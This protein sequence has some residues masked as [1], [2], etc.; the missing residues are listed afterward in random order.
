[1]KIG[2]TTLFSYR[3]HVEHMFY[4]AKQLK[5]AGHEVFFLNCPGGLESC[6]TQELRP[7]SPFKECLKCK[8]GSLYSYTKENTTFIDNSISEKLN[9]DELTR[10][11]ESS[12]HTIVRIEDPKQ[13]NLPELLAV[14]A[15]LEPA[16]E[17][18]YA[19]AKKWIKEK[20]LDFVYLFNGR[21]DLTKSV[22]K[23]CVDT[24]TNFCTVE[25]TF[26]SHG[27]QLNFNSHCLSLKGIH[28]ISKDFMD[29]PLS[30]E[31][32]YLAGNLVTSRFRNDSKLEWRHYNNSTEKTEWPNDV[33]GK[34]ILIMPSSRNEV[35]GDKD[36]ENTWN[37]EYIYVFEKV[38]HKLGVNFN[39]CVLRA[40]PN[41]GQNIGHAD[42]SRIAKY[43]RDWCLKT[44]VQFIE[45]TEEVT[46][47]QLMQ[48]ADLLIINGSSAVYESATLGL[49]TINLARSESMRA[50]IAYVILNEEEL[51]KYEASELFNCD[52]QTV[53]R[54]VLRFMY[55]YA[56]RYAL[57]RDD[58]VARDIYDFR[59]SEKIDTDRLEKMM[60]DG[61]I[62]PD[63]I[64]FADCPT[65]EN[66]V[67]DLILKR[68]W[69]NLVND[70]KM[71]EA[72]KSPLKR[73]GL[74]V[75]VDS[76]RNMFK[77]G[78]I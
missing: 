42:G 53:I 51:N 64:S 77:R 11:V 35:W 29:K 50:N 7:G 62:I 27:L 32:A 70:Q 37:E 67:I 40:H 41:W 23:A 3:P 66:E 76:I 14:Q 13:L 1:M 39:Q 22:L 24:K 54:N 5:M 45:P 56:V 58:I 57:F 74:Y 31:Q 60:T 48:Q 69:H 6:Y 49:P 17:I 52:K 34:K 26:L 33:A 15:R 59:Y 21:M 8:I 71:D 47:N 43:F 19:N 16:V 10:L 12:S 4:L 18:V 73:R 46:S 2:F 28:K 36:W 61:E 72:E 65:E 9:K 68:D 38:I 20:E 55:C 30:K 78:D 75:F 44:G 63:D 25:R